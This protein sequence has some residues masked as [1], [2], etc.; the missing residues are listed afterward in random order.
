MVAHGSPAGGKDRD[1][2]SGDRPSDEGRGAGVADHV[3]LRRPTSVPRFEPRAAAWRGRARRQGPGRGEVRYVFFDEI[4][5]L[6]DWE[7]HLK[8]MTDDRPLTKVTVSG[9]A[10]AALRLRSQESGAGRFTDFLLPPLTFYE[11]LDLVDELDLVTHQPGDRTLAFPCDRHREA[12]RTVHSLP[13]LWRISR[14]CLLT[15]LYN[16]ILAASHQ[17]RHRRQGPLARSA[18]PLWHLGRSGTQPA[19]H[20]PGLQHGRRRYRSS[21]CQQTPVWRRILLKRYIEYLEAAFLIRGGS[22]HRPLSQEVQA[23]YG[24]S[25]YTSPTRRLRAALFLTGT[26]AVPRNWD[27]W[28]KTAIF[29]QWFHQER[30]SVYYSRLAGWRGRHSSAWDAAQRSPMGRGGEMVRPLTLTI[31]FS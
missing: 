4:Q 10:A 15:C 27:I 16:R 13:Q 17:E 28:P 30:A 2:V 12:E 25:R 20:D 3:C 8:V 26:A 11:Y 22:P 24:R 19:V 5:Y 18:E 7:I 21:S 1:A 9:S 29:S 6:R 23:S 31:H 14:G